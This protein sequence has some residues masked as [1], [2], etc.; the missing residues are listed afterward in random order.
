MSLVRPTLC[1]KMMAELAHGPRYAYQLAKLIDRDTSM[2]SA[3]LKGQI[4]EGV[5]VATTTKPKLYRRAEVWELR[6]SRIERT[7]SAVETKLA[8]VQQEFSMLRQI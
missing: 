2:V 5:V 8:A 1:Q 3:I 7:L 4:K 6:L